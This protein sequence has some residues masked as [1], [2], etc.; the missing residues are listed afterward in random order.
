MILNEIINYLIENNVEWDKK[1]IKAV[2]H[3][4]GGNFMKA[5]TIAI[6]QSVIK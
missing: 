1:A 5:L 4:W 6:R 2:T 3:H